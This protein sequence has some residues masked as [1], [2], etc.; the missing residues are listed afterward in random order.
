MATIS[1]TVSSTNGSSTARCTLTVTYSVSSTSPTATTVTSTTLA[2]SAISVSGGTS[3][4]QATA[5]SNLVMTMIAALV[6]LTFGGNSVVYTSGITESKTVTF[7]GTKSVA[8]GHSATTSQLKLTAMGTTATAN[9]S[10]PVKTSYAVTYNANSG[11]SAPS[12]QTKWH[13]ETLAITSGEPKKTD[14]TFRGWSTSTGRA[15]TADIDY[16]A[17]QNY[18]ANQGLDLYAVWELTYRK[19]IIYNIQT[20]RCQQD[21][22]RDADGGYALV[23]FN[24]GVFNSTA[25]RYYGAPSGSETPYANNTADSS[26]VTVGNFTA[27]P[28]L[29]A[30]GGTAIVGDGSLNAD[31]IYDVSIS[32]TDSQQIVTTLADHT[33]T[34]MDVLAKAKFPIDINEDATAI[35]FLTTAP[36]DDEG[37]FC[38]DMTAQEVQDFV[39]NLEGGGGGGTVDRVIEQGTSGIW[40]YRKWE[41]GIAEC[42]GRQDIESTTY[43]ANGGYKAIPAALPSGLFNASPDIVIASGRIVGNVHTTMG[44]TSPNDAN[45]VQ[46][47]LINRNTSAVTTTGTVYWNIKGRWK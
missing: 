2:T 19:P 37:V 1:T 31:T 7:S 26:T 3:M 15:G 33:T 20:D 46:T 34:V 36:D 39:D 29:T 45:S 40:T 25:T 21:G 32:L 35:A 8:K 28:T 13:D 5:R 10:V 47:Y 9:I 11:S 22:T 4:T 30:T 17:G 27:T 44:F 18:T 12:N 6:E 43:A 16:V 38:P 24:W 23:K 14:Y 42:W 41:S